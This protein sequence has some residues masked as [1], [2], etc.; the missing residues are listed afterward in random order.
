MALVEWLA[1]L[2][3][4]IFGEPKPKMLTNSEVRRRFAATMLGA[5][6][7]VDMKG[8]RKDLALSV[9]DLE[10]GTGTGEIFRATNNPG[11]IKSTAGWV[12]RPAYKNTRVYRTLEEGIADWV[13]LISTSPR[14]ALAYAAA[15]AGHWRDFFSGLEKGGYEI[16]IYPPYSARLERRY[17]DI[18]REALA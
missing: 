9:F 18:K 4:A 3:R 7:R 17:S 12:G 2:L 15:Q 10:T 16:S 6:G 14:F 13:R 1:G 8:I 11:S 5:M